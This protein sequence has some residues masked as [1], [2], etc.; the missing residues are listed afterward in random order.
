[1]PEQ[2]MRPVILEK[3]PERKAKALIPSVVLSLEASKGRSSRAQEASFTA[4]E[5]CG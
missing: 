3:L 1:M 4:E 5:L 2:T